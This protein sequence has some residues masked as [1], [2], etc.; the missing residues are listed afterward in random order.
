M[1]IVSPT[2]TDTKTYIIELSDNRGVNIDIQDSTFY[3]SRFCKGM[4]AFKKK[5]VLDS[6][7]HIQILSLAD[8]IADPT[9]KS[10]LSIKD[11]TF[12]NLNQG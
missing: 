4:I 11:S 3:S 10:Q 5:P 12:Y 2:T 1:G 6:T 7:D 8:F 9:E